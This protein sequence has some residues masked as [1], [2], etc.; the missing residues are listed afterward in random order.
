MM[1]S[2]QAALREH[3][4]EGVPVAPHLEPPH[5]RSGGDVQPHRL[6][7]AV[8]GPVGVAPDLKRPGVRAR[9]VSGD[10]LQ[11]GKPL[12]LRRSPLNGHAKVVVSRAAT[13]RHTFAPFL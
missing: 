12:P 4:L 1:N 6:A 9:P 11:P 2:G 10:P 7:G 3:L 5:R 13:L 8:T